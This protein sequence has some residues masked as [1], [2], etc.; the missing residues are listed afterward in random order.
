MIMKKKLSIIIVVVLMLSFVGCIG[1]KKQDGPGLDLTSLPTGYRT[2]CL[3]IQDQSFG[4]LL[5][6]GDWQL[7]HAIYQGITMSAGELGMD[8]SFLVQFNGQVE[9]TFEGETATGTSTEKD[10]KLMISDTGTS[11]TIPAELRDGKLLMEYDGVE[12]YFERK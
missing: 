12:M 5:Y 9:F 6:V 8:A 2:L 3:S 4:I 11:E 1:P 7:S 10:G